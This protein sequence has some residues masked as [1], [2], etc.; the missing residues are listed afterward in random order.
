M[1]GIAASI[2]ALFPEQHLFSIILSLLQYKIDRDGLKK[3]DTSVTYNVSLMKD[4]KATNIRRKYD[5]EFKRNALRMIEQGQ[6]VRSLSQALGVAEGQLLKWRRVARAQRSSTDQE[7]AELRTRLRQVETERDILKN[8][9]S[10]FSR[11]T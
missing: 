10:I 11:Q 1:P 9:L 3:C 7:V 4:Q 5:G 2:I 8:A 6:S